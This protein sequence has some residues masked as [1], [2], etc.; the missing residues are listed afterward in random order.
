MARSEKLTT[1]FSS[2]YTAPYYLSPTHEK[3]EEMVD[4][5]IGGWIGEFL[6]QWAYRNLEVTGVENR[7]RMIERLCEIKRLKAE[8]PDY[9]EGGIA[10]LFGE[11]NS[12]DDQGHL[13]IDLVKH[14]PQDVQLDIGFTIN[15]SFLGAG[16][17]K[18]PFVSSMMRFGIK[19]RNI[20]VFP[21]DT[22][23][24]TGAGYRSMITANK[25]FLD[26]GG[27]TY[28]ATSDGRVK[29]IGL[30]DVIPGPSSYLEHASY[31]QPISLY[32]THK[33][34]DPNKRAWQDIKPWETCSMHYDEM[35]PTKDLF[36]AVDWTYRE[37]GETPGKLKRGKTALDVVMLHI[38]HNLPQEYQGFWEFPVAL[39]EYRG[40]PITNQT[41]AEQVSVV[42]RWR[43]LLAMQGEL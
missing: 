3:I 42:L 9:Q 41:L 22:K 28:V 38:A 20:T 2:E 4:P 14:V 43:E 34:F 15:D 39:A 31:V 13:M 25:Q 40:V 7:T 12:Y 29:S 23:R 24:G 33:Q 37:R 26:Q 16:S 19:R 8:N 5:L 1:G 10:V 35:I 18:Y 21:I 32:D 17:H 11:H 6:A 36:A 30:P 27:V